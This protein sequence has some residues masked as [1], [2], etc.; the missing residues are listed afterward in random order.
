MTYIHRPSRPRIISK[1][2]TSRHWSIYINIYASI[3]WTMSSIFNFLRDSKRIAGCKSCSVLERL[4]LWASYIRLMLLA[5]RSNGVGE[6]TLLDYR[7][8][9]LDAKSLFQL[10]REIFVNR[11]YD[12][13]FETNSPSIIDCGS[14][15][16]MSIFF[17]KSMYPRAKIRGFE[18]H[19]AIFQTLSENIKRNDLR[20]VDIHQ[21]ALSDRC[22]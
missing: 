3:M 16:G 13:P 4:G 12:V 14:N 15:I 1:Q 6:N 10:Y 17:F 2:R 20:Y 21:Q 19:P 11:Y 22:G 18:P 8:H 7:M 9:Y 5:S